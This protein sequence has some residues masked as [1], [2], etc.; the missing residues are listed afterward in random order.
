[1]VLGV[2]LSQQAG[3]PS[4]RQS[5]GHAGGGKS[6]VGDELAAVAGVGEVRGS[7]VEEAACSAGSEFW[8]HRERNGFPA[9]QW[10]VH[11]QDNRNIDLHAGRQS[12]AVHCL[13][14]GRTLPRSVIRPATYRGRGGNR[15]PTCRIALAQEV[16]NRIRGLSQAQADQSG[17]TLGEIRWFLSFGSWL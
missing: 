2:A 1:M 14:P 4:H 7:G 11:E 12:L 15:P 8:S 10:N 17:T 16:P 6:R 13:F 3:E 5:R 9:D